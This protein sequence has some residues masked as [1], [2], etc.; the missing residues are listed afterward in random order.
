MTKYR[1]QVTYGQLT[2][3]LLNARDVNKTGLVRVPVT[4]V[5]DA[6]KKLERKMR[7]AGVAPFCI[8][9]GGINNVPFWG[10]L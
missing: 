1:M 9:E 3:M 4:P 10:A 5:K 2:G 7:K 6:L 8:E